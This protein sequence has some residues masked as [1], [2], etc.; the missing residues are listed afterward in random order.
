[1]VVEIQFYRAQE[2]TGRNDSL[3]TQ[4]FT[5]KMNDMFDAMNRKLP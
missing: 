5:L 1:M 2:C 3:G 4:A